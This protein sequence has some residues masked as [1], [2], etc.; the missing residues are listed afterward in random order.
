MNLNKSLMDKEERIAVERKFYLSEMRD[1]EIYNAL[2]SRERNPKLKELLGRIARMEEKHT[3]LWKKMLDEDAVNIPSRQGTII[4]IETAGYTAAR[5][6]LGVAFVSKL[7]GRNEVSSLERFSGAVKRV[8]LTRKARGYLN[9]I[10]ND[11]ERNEEYLKRSLREHDSGLDYIG[12]IVL[13]LNDGLVEVL[14]AVTGIAV[15]ARA[16]FIVVVAGMIIGLSGTLSMA[17]GVYLSAKSHGLVQEGGGSEEFTGTNPRKDALYTGIYYFFG[18]MV[19][20]VPFIFGFEG[21]AGILLAIILVSAVLTFAS[22]VVA[23]VSNTSIKKRVFEMLAV[24]LGAA[25]AAILLG[26]VMKIKFGITI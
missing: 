22:V 12:S 19:S 17:G 21:F 25:F 8:G 3:M 26:V 14:A 6:I 2:A 5:R 7:L 10:I 9:T 20:I 15:L 16:G 18:A 11:E 23:V 4:A 13:G 1:Y 24:S